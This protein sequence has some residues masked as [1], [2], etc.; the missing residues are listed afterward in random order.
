[1]PGSD[2]E[3]R[4]AEMRTIV[5]ELVK[6]GLTEGVQL[7]LDEWRSV[8]IAFMSAVASTPA[9][10]LVYTVPAG[11]VMIIESFTIYNAAAACWF[12]LYDGLVHIDRIAVNAADSTVITRRYRIETSLNV[13]C[14]LWLAGTNYSFTFIEFPDTNRRHPPPA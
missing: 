7:K 10:G 6:N 5:Q 14:Q 4:V 1:M 3:D 13:I 12:D 11:K 9:I 2:F 8:D